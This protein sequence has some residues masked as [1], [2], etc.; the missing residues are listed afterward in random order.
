MTY[1][2][3]RNELHE[4]RDQNKRDPGTADVDRARVLIGHLTAMRIRPRR[5]HLSLRQLGLT[6]SKLLAKRRELKQ[7]G[8]TR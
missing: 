2:Q 1:E 6:E 4:I 5:V 3:I 7:L 8:P